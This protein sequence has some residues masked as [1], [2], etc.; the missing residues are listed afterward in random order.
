MLRLTERQVRILNARH[1]AT[2]ATVMPDGSPEATLVWIETDG[3]YIYFNT[4]FPRLKARNL[5]RDPRVAI[6]VFDPAH[7]YRDVLAIRGRAE[8]IMEGAREHIEKLARVYTGRAFKGFRQNQ[9][10]VIVKMTPERIHL[11]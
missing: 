11:Q 5:E 3:E 8:L 10:R 4:A 9:T 2:V 1:F 7:P 6:V